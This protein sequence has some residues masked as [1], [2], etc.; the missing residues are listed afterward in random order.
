MGTQESPG[1]VWTSHHKKQAATSHLTVANA[2]PISLGARPAPLSLS[3]L[4]FIVCWRLE[5]WRKDE[6]ERST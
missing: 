2:V 5:R 4:L 3:Q 1:R 6:E